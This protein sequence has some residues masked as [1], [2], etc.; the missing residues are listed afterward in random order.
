MFKV[1]K[2]NFESIVAAGKY[3][4]TYLPGTIVEADISTLGLMV[5]RTLQNAISFSLYY[6]DPIILKV[7][8][9]EELTPKTNLFTNVTSEYNLDK[10]YSFI[11]RSTTITTSK[12]IDVVNEIPVPIPLGTKFFRRVRVIKEVHL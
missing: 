10:Y 5:F 3:C 1:T 8:G 4:K 7:K 2:S 9:I 12:F 6:T 11:N